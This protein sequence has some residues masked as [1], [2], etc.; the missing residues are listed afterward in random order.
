MS[1]LKAAL[2]DYRDARARV[3]MIANEH[4]P[5]G[6]VVRVDHPR[7]HGLGILVS[8]AAEP[9]RVDVLLENGNVWSYGIETIVERIDDINAWPTWVRE[10]KLRW[11]LEAQKRRFRLTKEEQSDA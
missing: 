8:L 3:R 6:S 10:T 5:A 7:F 1:S 4:L 9:E 11:K 2:N